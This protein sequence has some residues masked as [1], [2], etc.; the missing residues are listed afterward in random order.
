M[1]KTTIVNQKNPCA[2]D[3]R[4]CYIDGYLELADHRYRDGRVAASQCLVFLYTTDSAS[5]SIWRWVLIDMKKP[6]ARHLSDQLFLR[7]TLDEGIHQ[8][9]ALSSHEKELSGTYDFECEEGSTYFLLVDY[10]KGRRAT[11]EKM[12]ENL[13]REDIVSRRLVIAP[14]R[15][16]SPNWR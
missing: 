15:S 5:K 14:D 6:P 4:I 3:K 1:R 13:A 16:T 12:N 10:E 8:I 9:K 7:V 11:V 2:D